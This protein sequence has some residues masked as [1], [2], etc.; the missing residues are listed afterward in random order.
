MD[1]IVNQSV[2][3]LHDD[4]ADASSGLALSIDLPTVM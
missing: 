3:S 4:K 1:D 2:A